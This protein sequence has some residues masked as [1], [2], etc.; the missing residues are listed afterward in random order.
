MTSSNA[1]RSRHPFP[2]AH[3]SLTYEEDP[4]MS[5]TPRV[6]ARLLAGQAHGPPV[7]P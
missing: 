1:F 6:A 4:A 5:Q 2:A 7:A 3:T